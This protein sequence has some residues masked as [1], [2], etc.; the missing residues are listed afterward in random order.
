MIRAV[1][2]GDLATARKI[3]RRLVPVVDAI[4]NTSQGAIMA[5]AALVEL[6]VLTSATVRLPLLESSG[7]DLARLHEG[8]TRS[9]IR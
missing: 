5:K 6:G 9:G 1:E 8:L 4:M 7:D 2:V 3:H